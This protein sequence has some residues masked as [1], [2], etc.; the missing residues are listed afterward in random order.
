MGTINARGGIA[1]STGSLTSADGAFSF[2]F[3]KGQ[4]GNFNVAL[5]TTA[6]I[7]DLIQL[8]TSTVIRT[9]SETRPLSTAVVPRLHV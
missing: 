7:N 4:V 5:G 9:A 2:S 8:D 1:D 6:A 3:R